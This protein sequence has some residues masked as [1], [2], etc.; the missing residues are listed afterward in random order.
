MAHRTRRLLAVA[1]IL[2]SLASTLHCGS[3]GPNDDDDGDSCTQPDQDG[4]IG[5]DYAFAVDVSDTAFSPVI[6]KAQN[7]GNV[8]LT[9]KN[10]G[11]KPHSF[12]VQC[13]TTQG[14]TACFPDGA[15]VAPLEPGATTT[16][17]FVA[18][19]QEG[20]FTIASDVPGDTFTAQFI[21]Q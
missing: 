21:L 17:K 13:L 15:K 20:I 18:P 9:V 16:V 14:C 4:V 7:S 8:T 6:L 19:E 12:V 3:D 2:C 10:T 1:S 11:T 5:G